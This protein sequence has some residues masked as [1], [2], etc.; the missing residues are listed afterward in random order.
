[1]LQRT[2]ERLLCRAETAGAEAVAEAGRVHALNMLCHLYQDKA[3][4]LSVLPFVARGF[5]T[6]FG[7]LAAAEW[8]V[9]NSAT[10]LLSALLE[11]A[12][13]NRRSKDEHSQAKKQSP[14][15]Q[16]MDLPPSKEAPNPRCSLRERAL[17]NR[18]TI[19]R[20]AA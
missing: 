10:M 11:R 8:G 5:R 19:R 12:L 9:R 3:F 4:G 14:L 2:V 15:F 20:R 13:R 16:A 7:A 18:R 6:A 1:M 17:R